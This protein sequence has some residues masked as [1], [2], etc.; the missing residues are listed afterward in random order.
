MQKI[1]EGVTSDIAVDYK[2]LIRKIFILSSF[3]ED[4]EYSAIFAN[5]QTHV[6]VTACVTSLASVVLLQAAC[7]VKQVIQSFVLNLV[8]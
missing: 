1:Q 5:E 8:K 4:E 7:Q 2:E 6:R 3:L